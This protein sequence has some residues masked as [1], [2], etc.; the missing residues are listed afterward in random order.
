VYS[1]GA[2]APH[3][4]PRLL[5]WSWA[6]AFEPSHRTIILSQIAVRP[7]CTLSQHHEPTLRIVVM[8][9]RPCAGLPPSS[10][11][12]PTRCTSTSSHLEPPCQAP[13]C[14][15]MCSCTRASLS[16]NHTTLTD[17]PAPTPLPAPHPPPPAHTHPSPPTHPPPRSPHHFG[18]TLRDILICLRSCSWAVALEHDMLSQCLKPVY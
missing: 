12:E 14:L 17:P 5:V 13:V 16:P 15:C 2:A 6:V 7:R 9:Y 8:G 11:V 18:P 3:E 10:H 1:L 4:A